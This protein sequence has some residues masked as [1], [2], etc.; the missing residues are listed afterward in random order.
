[1]NRVHDD[2]QRTILRPNFPTLWTPLYSSLLYCSSEEYSGI[3]KVGQYS[4]DPVYVQMLMNGEQLSMELDTG[5][6][7]SMHHFGKD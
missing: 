1:M 5:A 4:N 3:H 7:V 2:D 6:E